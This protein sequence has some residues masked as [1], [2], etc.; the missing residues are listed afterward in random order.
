MGIPSL[1]N[2]SRWEKSRNSRRQSVGFPVPIH[3]RI[4]QKNTS[5]PL[6]INY[7]QL[8]TMPNIMIHP[9]GVN[10]LLDGMDCN[11]ATGPDFIPTRVLKG[12]STVLVPILAKIFQKSI[13]TG[14]IPV[15]LTANV[16]A[17]FKKGDKHDPS[18]YRP[19]SLQV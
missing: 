17:V 18:N 15:L 2:D 11:K 16:V 14:S 3:L 6:L 8:P 4:H 9:N 1:Y 5:T 7:K 13:D 10:K 12:C 19:I